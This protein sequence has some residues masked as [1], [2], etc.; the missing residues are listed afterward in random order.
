MDINIVISDYRLLRSVKLGTHR[1]I[2]WPIGRCEA[3][4]NDRSTTLCNVCALYA[5]SCG[6]EWC[7]V[8]QLDI[9]PNHRYTLRGVYALLAIFPCVPSFR[10][11]AS[12]IPVQKLQNV[13]KLAFFYPP[14]RQW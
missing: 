11:S 7:H 1:T 5:F 12:L 3:N 10:F 8:I 9:G 2:Y 13:T 4:R 14:R 6:W